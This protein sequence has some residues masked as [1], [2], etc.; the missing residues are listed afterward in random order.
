MK[1]CGGWSYSSTHFLPT[2][3]DEGEW[4]PLPPGGLSPGKE[5]PVLIFSMLGGPQ[6][7]PGFCWRR[8]KCFAPTGNRTPIPHCPFRSLVTTPT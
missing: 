3:L 2:L 1:T 4:S 7:R 5:S 6:N 8:E